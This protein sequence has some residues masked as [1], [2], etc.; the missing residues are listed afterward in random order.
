MSEEENLREALVGAR[1]RIAQLYALK[2]LA[3]Q[4]RHEL[5]EQIR[6]FTREQDRVQV[7]NIASRRSLC[8]QTDRFER[9]RNEA[10]VQLTDALTESESLREELA[11]VRKSLDGVRSAHQ[12]SL[13]RWWCGPGKHQ[14]PTETCPDHPVP[15]RSRRGDAITR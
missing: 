10:R 6:F 3:V 2:D 9:E 7:A 8:E 12:Q 1:A 5:R 11:R 14:I 13:Q 4:E 15:Y